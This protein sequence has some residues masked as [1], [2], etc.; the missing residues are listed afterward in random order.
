VIDGA[1]P[2]AGGGQYCTIS[3]RTA[4]SLLQETAAGAAAVVATGTCASF[5]GVPAAK[6]NPTRAV[7]VSA[8]VSGKTVV[9]VSGC[10][11]IPDV[12]NGSI[13]YFLVN[14]TAPP[15]DSL[16]RPQTFFSTVIHEICPRRH[17][18]EEERF[19]KSFDDAGAR[20]GYCLFQLGCKGP[21]T[22]SSCPSKGWLDGLSFPIQSGHPCIGCT[23]PRFWDR[24]HI[25][26]RG[27]EPD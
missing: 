9:N 27:P 26:Q 1:V 3:G 13:A 18:F 8:L 15:L 20:K 24:Y 6:P 7:P 17:N 14:G 22:H 5:G 2:T 25:Y 10:P 23:E 12:L 11:P 21:I 4:V 19:A 16:N